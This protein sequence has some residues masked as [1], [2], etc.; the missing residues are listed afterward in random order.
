MSKNDSLDSTG[1]ARAPDSDFELMRR[2][3][4]ASATALCAGG[5]T[6]SEQLAA[7]VDHADVLNATARRLL[8]ALELAASRDATAMRALRLA[9]CQ[10]TLARRGE[11]LAPER[12]LIDLKELVDK[13]AM[14]PIRTHVTDRSSNHFRERVSMWCIN[15][16][17]NSE[18]ACT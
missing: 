10:F 18:G 3:A 5:G 17:F 13:R 11:G 1:S 12:V 15:A 2:I 16:Y 9:V 7:A 8:E 14:P 6:E 4:E